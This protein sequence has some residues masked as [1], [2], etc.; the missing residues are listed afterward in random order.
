MKDEFLKE[1]PHYSII[2]Y[3]GHGYK[4]RV[5]FFS[6]PMKKS[7]PEFE[8]AEF[9]TLRKAWRSLNGKTVYMM[10]EWDIV[11]DVDILKTSLRKGALIFLDACETGKHVYAG[12]GHFQGLAHAFLKKG[13]SSVISSLIPFHGAHAG[14]FSLSFYTN[15]LSQKPVS[16][17]LQNTR[18]KIKEEHAPHMYWLPYIHYGCL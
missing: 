2:H 17:A 7:P 9:V 1:L 4:G 13:A 10:D 12:G 6:G 14:D 16:A 3:T 15:L 8:P 5:L 11:T 18:K